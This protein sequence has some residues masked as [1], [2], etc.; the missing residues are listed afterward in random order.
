[1]SEQ[2]G[3][4]ANS[5]ESGQLII[6]RLQAREDTDEGYRGPDGGSEGKGRAGRRGCS[7]DTSDQT[8]KLLLTWGLLQSRVTLMLPGSFGYGTKQNFHWFYSHLGWKLSLTNEVILGGPRVIMDKANTTGLE[9]H[10]AYRCSYPILDAIFHAKRSLF[11][12]TYRYWD[13]KPY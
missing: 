1:M 4:P 7:C 10:S 3:R 13:I 12:S 9:S 2:C 5:W 8:G 6:M 11:C